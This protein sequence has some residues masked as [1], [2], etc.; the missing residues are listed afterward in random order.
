MLSAGA[1]EVP[2]VYKNIEDV[3]REQQDLVDDRGPVRSE[4]RQDVRRRQLG[5][6]LTAVEKGDRHFAATS[7]PREIRSVAQSQSPFSTGCQGHDPIGRNAAVSL[8]R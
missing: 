7:Q 6:G 5:R 1:D 2:G 3:M 8:G 4:D